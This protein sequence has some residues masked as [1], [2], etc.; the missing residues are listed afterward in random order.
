MKDTKQEADVMNGAVR[1]SDFLA[2]FR[3][4]PEK[5]RLFRESE[6][7]F[8]LAHR[9][10]DLRKSRGM[11]QAELA[12]RV[13]CKQPFIAKLE[14]GAYDRVGL[15]TIRTYARAMGYDISLD[16]L[17]QDIQEP[18]FTERSSCGA[19]EEALELQHILSG[20]LSTLSIASWSK[21]EM[22][23]EEQ[24]M[25]GRPTRAAVE[26]ETAA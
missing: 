22:K 26:M 24:V 12:R 13:G 18:A 2:K 23:F 1:A 7:R 6:V 16:A 8:G 14:A 21:T 19:L 4:D 3:S 15:S 11:S 17:F 5:D 20:R 9:M 25:T 10:K